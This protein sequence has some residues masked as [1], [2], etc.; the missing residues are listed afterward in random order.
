V[1]AVICTARRS[2]EA[3]R[4]RGGEEKLERR[5]KYAVVKS[6]GKQYLAQEGQAIE[7][8]RLSVEVGKRVELK[9]VLMVVDGKEV[10]I[11]TPLV[12]GARVKARVVDHV[13]AS[14]V[15]IFKYIPKER[16]RRK[17]GHRQQYTR[18]MVE[19]IVLPGVSEKPAAETEA[20][21]AEAAAAVASQARPKPAAE[22]RPKAVAR[23]P[24]EAKPRAPAKPAKK[25]AAGKPAPKKAK[26]ESRAKPSK[27]KK[28][29]EKK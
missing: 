18:L 20:A 21:V 17:A 23:K 4:G 12:D 13:K 25:P 27:G 19:G 1:A 10:R 7:V 3:E 9:D 16:Y 8:D 15:I 28:S 2:N 24:A 22:R 26:P 11:G 14:K 29:A 6:G 5:M